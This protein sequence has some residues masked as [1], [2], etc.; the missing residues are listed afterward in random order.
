MS[1]GKQ[2]FSGGFSAAWRE[3]GQ[4]PGLEHRPV[5]DVVELGL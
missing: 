2:A 3:W 1:R 4:F 5:L